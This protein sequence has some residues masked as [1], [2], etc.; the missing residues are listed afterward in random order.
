[1]P[2]QSSL[3]YVKPYLYGVTDQGVVSIYDPA[4][5]G[6]LVKQGRIP[7][8]YCASPIAADDKIYFCSEQGEVTVIK[9]GDTI[10]VIATNS[11]GE[12]IQASPAISQGNIFIRT[13]K[14]LYCIGT[15][16]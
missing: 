8:N 13:E 10:D 7:G 5:K 16:Q 11:L 6:K 1:V 15:A 14:N 12:R 2:S 4:A 3:I 9:A